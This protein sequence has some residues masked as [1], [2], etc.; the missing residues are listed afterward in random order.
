MDF[1]SALGYALAAVGRADIELKSEQT[2]AIRCIY[3]G[4]DVFLWL[5]F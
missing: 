5:R 3:E 2:Q 4:E 1:Q